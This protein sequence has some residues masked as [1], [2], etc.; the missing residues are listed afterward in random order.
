MNRNIY[1]KI[2]IA[3]LVVRLLF[4]SITGFNSYELH[5]DSYRY[6]ELSDRIMKG[7]YNMDIQLFIV[8]PFYP[9]FIALHKIIFG[10]LW[11]NSLVVSQLILSSL[12]GIFLFKLSRLLFGRNDVSF[13]ATGLYCIFPMTLY[14]SH[15]FAQE[16]VFQSFLII[17]IYL[18]LK[19]IKE[20]A[21]GLLLLSAL[22]FSLA[23]LTKAHL[24]LFSPF[25]VVVIY[26]NLKGT[27]SR[28]L[29]FIFIF[30][31]FCLAATLPMGLYNLKKH[32]TYTLSG[33]GAGI[34]FYL[35]NTNYSYCFIANTPDK[36]SDEFASLLDPFGKGLSLKNGP[37]YDSI[38]G[39]PQ[40][41]KQKL[42][43]QE[44]VSWIREN[45]SKFLELKAINLF[46]FIMPGVSFSHY[47]FKNALFSFLISL[48]IYLFGYIGVVVAI[49][50]DYKTHSW[51]IG[52]FIAMLIFSVGFYVQN[53]F[54]TITIEPFFI[55][56][57]AYGFFK[58][59]YFFIRNKTLDPQDSIND[60]TN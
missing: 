30:S 44:G 17:F 6:I 1:L 34:L 46:K 14:W 54:R 60:I 26:L 37:S 16:S 42:Y 7:D 27:V 20:N 38:T 13:L 25:I 8:A 36:N 47:S 28:K 9:F 24:L 4:I 21:L 15:T 2:F 35:G 43:F 58:T 31:G 3:F 56:Y 48:P 39:L 49:K 40:E 45:P 10:S 33:N 23:F 52:M 55:V 41:I 5:P 53:R 51:I 29:I 18:L 22:L 59:F 12:S 19:A 57:S 32:S 50:E 11:E